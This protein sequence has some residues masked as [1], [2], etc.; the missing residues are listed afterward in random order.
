ME[1]VLQW[2]DMRCRCDTNT[3]TLWS[4]TNSKDKM[5]VTTLATSW[6]YVTQ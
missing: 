3:S 6:Q 2:T 1:C 4:A 5:Q